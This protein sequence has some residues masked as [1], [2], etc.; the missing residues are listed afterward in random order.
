MLEVI[1]WLVMV[2]GS[3][4]YTLLC[5]AMVFYGGLDL[6]GF[7]SPYYNKGKGGKWNRPVAVAMCIACVV[8]WYKVAMISPFI[9]ELK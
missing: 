2:F 6:S 1:G 5:Y 8:I 7:F 4:W 9:L 3:A